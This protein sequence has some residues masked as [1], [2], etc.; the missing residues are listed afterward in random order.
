MHNAAIKMIN[1]PTTLIVGSRG[2]MAE[3]VKEV[4]PA[5]KL[6]EVDLQNIAELLDHTNQFNDSRL[7]RSQISSILR[8]HS[9]QT[10]T[11]HEIN[12][13]LYLSLP[14]RLYMDAY[15]LAGSRAPIINLTGVSGSGQRGT[16]VLFEA[17]VQQT[18][19]KIME[20]W[21][22]PALGIHRMHS[23][24]VKDLKNQVVIISTSEK[25]RGHHLNTEANILV[26]ALLKKM[27]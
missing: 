23:P 7:A 21:S 19:S 3:A 5:N 15:T 1:M 4:I 22:G 2:Q 27:G 18:I 20:S 14:N 26:R 24:Q 25:K 16:L 13:L 12:Y 17:S 6:H 9:K 11:V 10:D 8:N